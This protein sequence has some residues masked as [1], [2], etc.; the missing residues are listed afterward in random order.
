MHALVQ[1]LPVV[2]ILVLS[3]LVFIRPARQRAAQVRELQTALTPGDEIMLGSG[4][5]GRVVALED[6]R[7]RVEVAPDVVLTV[8]RG[9]VEKMIRDD[10]ADGPEAEVGPARGRLD[11]GSVGPVGRDDTREAS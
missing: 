1:L 8:H 5:F 10:V 4:I 11:V 6:L 9:A 3:Y 7:V 2:V